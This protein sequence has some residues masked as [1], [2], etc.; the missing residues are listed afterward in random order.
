MSLP[1]S[2]R[3]GGVR[4]ER[5]KDQESRLF[6]EASRHRE[7]RDGGKE[8]RANATVWAMALPQQPA[9]RFNALRFQI[10]DEEAASLKF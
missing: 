6:A 10:V 8:R 4:T 9:G 7:D 2:A 3:C 1:V 5:V